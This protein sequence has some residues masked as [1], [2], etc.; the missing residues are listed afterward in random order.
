MRT[1]QGCEHQGLTGRVSSGEIL[2][3][4]FPVLTLKPEQ[5]LPKSEEGN[6]LTGDFINPWMRSHA[7][8]Q[9]PQ[10]QG[11][12]KGLFSWNPKTRYTILN[13]KEPT[14]WTPMH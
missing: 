9:L 4:H 2:T 6:T 5:T 13:K 10:S 14:G 7:A 11:G 3:T 12:D 1:Q 8:H